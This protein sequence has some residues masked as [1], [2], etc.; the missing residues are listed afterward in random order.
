MVT[1]LAK[2]AIS[3]SNEIAKNTVTI[4][5]DDV[6]EVI[7]LLSKLDENQKQIVLASMRG[8]V[9]IADAEKKGA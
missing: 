8:A 6:N 5:L 2:E 3:L 7:S 4:D 9:L 1:I